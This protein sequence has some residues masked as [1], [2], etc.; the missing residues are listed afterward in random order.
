MEFTYT[1]VNPKISFHAI[2]GS[3]HP[4]TIRII[5]RVENQRV[6]ILIDSGST[7]NFLDSSIVK[8]T[9]LLLNQESII[10]V[11]LAN[12]EQLLSE[13]KCAGVRVEM[14]QFSFITEAF[15][16]VIWFLAING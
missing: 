14:Q 7:H 6:V 8:K 16:I 11:Q 12:G 3:S 1:D 10:K 5:G 9:Q 4:K 13:S 2:T 15:V